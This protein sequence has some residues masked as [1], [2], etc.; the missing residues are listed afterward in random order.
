MLGFLMK[1]YGNI[2]L[3]G[4]LGLFNYPRRRHNVLQ[5]AT[6]SGN[7]IWSDIT[8]VTKLLRLILE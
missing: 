3:N 5:C 4:I 8:C 1:I 6:L 7:R 2:F